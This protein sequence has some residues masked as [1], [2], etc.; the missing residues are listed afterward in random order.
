MVDFQKISC[1]SG[2]AAR[3]TGNAQYVVPYDVSDLF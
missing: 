2:V 1:D 3:R